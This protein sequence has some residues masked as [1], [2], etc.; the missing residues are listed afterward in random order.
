M[1]RRTAGLPLMYTLPTRSGAAGGDES[2]HE[3]SC[4]TSANTLGEIR[5]PHARPQLVTPAISRCPPPPSTSS[6]PPESP[7]QVVWPL[8]LASAHSIVAPEN[9][10]P[11]VA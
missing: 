11:A 1:V 9:G 7:R 2:S 3:R 10:N 8:G 5:E 4:S 6:G